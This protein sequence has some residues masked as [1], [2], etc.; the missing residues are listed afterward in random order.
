MQWTA[1]GGAFSTAY[2][3]F[4]SRSFEIHPHV[5]I[6][7]A[8]RVVRYSASASKI[9]LLQLC[10]PYQSVKMDTNAPHEKAR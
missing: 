2:E 7:D 10:R 3:F 6:S 5:Q 8:V 9:W 1:T 4:A